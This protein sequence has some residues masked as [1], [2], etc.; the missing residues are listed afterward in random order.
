MAA[1]SGC[2]E[3]QERFDKKEDVYNYTAQMYL[4]KEAWENLEKKE[5]KRLRSSF[6]TVCLGL[7]YG[8]G[9]Q[10]LATRL[11]CS[12]EEAQR[13]IDVFYSTYPRVKEYIKEQGD[14]VLS[15]GGYVNNFFGN[16]IQ[17]DE[18]KYYQEATTQ[19]EK[20]NQEARLKRLGVNLPIRNCSLLK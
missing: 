8:L 1:M 4:G 5:K 18:W 3:L 20:K 15:H 19:R 11:N 12:V 17:P 7:M 9:K 2:K 14:Y 10:S 13:L 6:K 16:K